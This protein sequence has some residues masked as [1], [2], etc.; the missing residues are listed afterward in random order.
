MAI[1]SPPPA[2][3]D[4]LATIRVVSL[5]VLPLIGWLDSITGYEIGFFIFYFLPVAIAAWY[6]GTTD[7]ICIAIVSAVCWYVSALVSG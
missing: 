3:A 5:V 4:Y 6:Y 7:G 1:Y 2:F